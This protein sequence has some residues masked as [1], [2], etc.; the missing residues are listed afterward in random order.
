MKAREVRLDRREYLNPAELLDI[1]D[2][3]DV[4]K[5]KVAVDRL[6]VLFGLQTA[7]GKDKPRIVLPSSSR[8]GGL[9][10]TDRIAEAFKSPGI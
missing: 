3:S 1:L 10:I 4:E 5:F 9:G 7:N 2:T 6:P 8:S